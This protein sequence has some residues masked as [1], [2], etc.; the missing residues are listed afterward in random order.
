[1]SKHIVTLPENE[2]QDVVLLALAE[3]LLCRIANRQKPKSRRHNRLK[4][5]IE[6][7]EKIDDTYQG[8]TSDAFIEHLEALAEQVDSA[9]AEY[10][11]GRE[12]G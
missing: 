1:M 5:V 6:G 2:K 4:A 11:R 3:Y 9:T 12:N 7:I 10:M 8:K